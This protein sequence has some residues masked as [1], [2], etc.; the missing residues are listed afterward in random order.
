MPWN[1]EPEKSRNVENRKKTRELIKLAH[2][3]HLNFFSFAN[4][5]TFHPSLL[6]AYD[7]S[8]SPCD[9]NFWQALQEKYRQL[10]SALPELDGIELCTDDLSGFWDN[11]RSFDLMHDGEGCEWPLAKRYRTFVEKIWQVVVGEFN[12]TYFHFTWGLAAHEQHYS[13]EV[14]RQI[15]TSRVSVVFTI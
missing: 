14:F 2:A 1:V 13:A 12:K 7:A 9:A 5:F 6:Q 15:F 11:Y 8:L 3:L 4:E 10:F